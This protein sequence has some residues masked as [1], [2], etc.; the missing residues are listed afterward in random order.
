MLHPVLVNF[1]L[2]IKTSPLALKH[3]SFGAYIDFDNKTAVK[4]AHNAI[5]KRIVS[6]LVTH[7][8]SVVSFSAS[9]RQI[10]PVS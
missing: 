3:A 10:M 9:R 6:T 1:Y 8:G 5:K 7:C 4:G 2:N